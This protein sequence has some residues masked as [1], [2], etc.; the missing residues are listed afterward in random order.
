MQECGIVLILHSE[1]HLK[2]N[3]P[4]GRIFEAAAASCVVISDRHPF[5]IQEFGDSVLYIDQDESAEEMA[6][7][8]ESHLGWI[9][10]HPAAAQEMA[11]KCH[12][13]FEERFTLEQQL[14]R[15]QT[16]YNN[17]QV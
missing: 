8:I 12:R 6:R 15:L 5:V 11:E 14:L 16:V 9:Q 3:A 1:T 13:I 17:L 4:T 7:Q 2:G 10:S